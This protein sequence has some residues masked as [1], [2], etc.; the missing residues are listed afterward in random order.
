[1]KLQSLYENALESSNFPKFYGALNDQDR[2][3]FDEILTKFKK[4]TVTSHDDADDQLL[5][6]VSNGI[7]EFDFTFSLDG[8]NPKYLALDLASMISDKYIL[9]ASHINETEFHK[10]AL[11]QSFSR[12]FDLGRKQ[13]A[14]EY[15]DYLVDTSEKFTEWYFDLSEK[16]G[17]ILLTK[18]NLNIEDGSSSG[19]WNWIAVG[20]T[21]FAD[22]MPNGKQV[23]AEIL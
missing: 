22:S 2:E 8:E 14:L 3:T 11:T 7:V 9:Y 23:K 18:A 20:G 17:K 10:I 19:V 1:M 21:F 15:V 16:H 6:H 12:D 4:F 5:I 13:K